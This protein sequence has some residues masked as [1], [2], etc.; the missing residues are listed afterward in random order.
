MNNM[1]AADLGLDS[2]DQIDPSFFNLRVVRQQAERRAVLRAIAISKGNLSRAAELLGI[3]RP[4]LYDLLKTYD[5]Q[6]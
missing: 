5:L 3:T 2:A 6:A 1:T 4:T